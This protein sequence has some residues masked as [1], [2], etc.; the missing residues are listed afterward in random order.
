M[1]LLSNTFMLIALTLLL[2]ACPQ[3]LTPQ[4]KAEMQIMYYLRNI[5]TNSLYRPGDFSQMNEVIP[6]KIDYPVVEGAKYM[7]FH[8]YTIDG[9]IRKVKRSERFYVSQDYKVVDIEQIEE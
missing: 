8:S 6:G 7:I 9:E 4:M 1:K 3:S 5:H 2:Y